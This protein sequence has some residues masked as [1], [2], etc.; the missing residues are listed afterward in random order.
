MIEILM[1]VP[2][3]LQGGGEYAVFDEVMGAHSAYLGASAANVGDLDGD[4]V[5]DFAVGAYWEGHPPFAGPPGAV[6]VYSGA[7]WDVIY[8][9]YGT[10]S[11]QGFGFDV[12]RAGDVDADGVGDILIGCKSWNYPGSAFVIS[13]ANGAILYQ[14]TGSGV[15]YEAFGSA[16]SGLD[17]VDGD[18]HDDF[19]IGDSGSGLGGVDRA[20]AVFLYSGR[21]GNVLFQVDGRAYGDGFGWSLESTPDMDG[22][23]IRDFLVGAPFSDPL[24]PPE[25]E[26]VGEVR[27]FSGVS[28]QELFLIPGYQTSGYFGARSQ[29]LGIST[30]TVCSILL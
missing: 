5:D 12:A 19:L 8:D 27:G 18:G 11:N 2:V 20:G 1:A 14:F 13:G 29:P 7:T 4:G 6:H 16:M 3:A 25:P 28:G 17:D 9:L 26:R 10:H 15:S 21:T 24:S 30:G 23:G 22:D